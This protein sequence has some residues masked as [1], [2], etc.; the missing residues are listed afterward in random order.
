MQNCVKKSLNG[1]IKQ[2]EFSLFFYLFWFISAFAELAFHSET[3]SQE[4]GLPPVFLNQVECQVCLKC[5]ENSFNSSLLLFFNIISFM[6]LFSVI[7]HQKCFQNL[8]TSTGHHHLLLGTANII[9][10]EKNYSCFENQV[11]KHILNFFSWAGHRG[12]RLITLHRLHT[13]FT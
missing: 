4:D 12:N 2:H 13:A 9:D 7:K 10:T 11:I 8:H 1:S 3:T 6:R 5:K